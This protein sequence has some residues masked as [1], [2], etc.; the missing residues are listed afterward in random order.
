M[1]A[2]DRFLARYAILRVFRHH[3]K[4]E[5]DVAFHEVIVLLDLLIVGYEVVR[6]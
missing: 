4:F 2:E 5:A 6:V 3:D 1:F